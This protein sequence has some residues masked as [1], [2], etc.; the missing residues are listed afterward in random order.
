MCWTSGIGTGARRGEPTKGRGYSHEFDSGYSAEV[1]LDRARAKDRVEKFKKDVK[2]G[3][4]VVILRKDPPY[5][6]VSGLINNETLKYCDRGLYPF[7]AVVKSVHSDGIFVSV[8]LPE[9]G[10]SCSVEPQFVLTLKDIP[11]TQKQVELARVCRDKAASPENKEYA[12]RMRS[13]VSILCN[14]RNSSDLDL[15]EIARRMLVEDLR[16]LD[17]ATLNDMIKDTEESFI[18]RFYKFTGLTR[19]LEVKETTDE[20]VEKAIAM[21]KKRAQAEAERSKLAAAN[22]EAWRVAIHDIFQRQGIGS[23]ISAGVKQHG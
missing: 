22:A 17:T 7:E 6:E 16:S 1:I 19:Q 23:D 15:V 13:M 18:T 2:P 4:T 3:D 20:R 21:E 11:A 10:Y 5:I 14:G 8:F 9:F 12:R